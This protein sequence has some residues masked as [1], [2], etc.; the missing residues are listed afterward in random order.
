VNSQDTHTTRRAVEVRAASAEDLGT[1]QALLDASGLPSAD[2][3]EHF[4]HFVVARDGDW[5]VGVAGMEQ[6]GEA[7]LLRSVC[8]AEG[9][10]GTGLGRAL[11]DEMERRAAARGVGALYLLTTTAQAFFEARHFDV[12]DR[13]EAPEVIRGT[14]EFRSLCPATA[15]CMR[16]RLEPRQT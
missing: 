8:V 4:K 11:C 10:R 1:V 16:K 3:A 14:A 13:A 5:L 12:I 2:V 6:Y 9:A 7:A 15:I